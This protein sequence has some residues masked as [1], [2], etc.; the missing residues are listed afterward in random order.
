MARIKEVGLV[1]GT[2]VKCSETDMPLTYYKR[3]KEWLCD[4]CLATAKRL[5]PSQN[6]LKKYD[7]KRDLWRE[8]T[9]T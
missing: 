4:Y 7:K 1:F 6:Y 5:I 8:L 9:A 2:C 3:T